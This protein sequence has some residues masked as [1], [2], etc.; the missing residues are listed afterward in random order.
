MRNIL[1]LLVLLSNFVFGDLS[2]YIKYDERFFADPIYKNY[3]EI[4][5]FQAQIKKW[6]I[7]K[8]KYGNDWNIKIDL[9]GG[10][11]GHIWGKGVPI[12]PGI[13]NNLE[14]Y[15]EINEEYLKKLCLNF[16]EEN[17]DIFLIDPNE[18]RF[19]GVYEE[20]DFWFVNMK[21]YFKGI[22]V[23]GS[24][25]FIK[26]SKGNIISFFSTK[27]GTI[28]INTNPNYTNI[29]ARESLFQYLGG[30]EENDKILEEKLLI[31]PIWKNGESETNYTGKVGE[32]YDH[33][34]VW[35]IRF[36]RKDEG[37]W[38]GIIDA[39]TNEVLSFN[40]NFVEGYYTGSITGSIYLHDKENGNIFKENVGMPYA[41]IDGYIDCYKTNDVSKCQNKDNLSFTRVYCTSGSG[42]FSYPDS[43]NGEFMTRLVS[44]YISVTSYL[45]IYRNY[46]CDCSTQRNPHGYTFMCVKMQNDPKCINLDGNETDN[47]CDYSGNPL[48]PDPYYNV[49]GNNNA[50][51]TAYYHGNYFKQ[52]WK[53]QHSRPFDWRT[54][55]TYCPQPEGSGLSQW[56]TSPTMIYVNLGVIPYYDDDDYVVL[57]TNLSYTNNNN[58]NVSLKNGGEYPS[59]LYHELGHGMDFHD[60]SCLASTEDPRSSTEGYADIVTAIM[61]RDSCLGRGMNEYGL[62]DEQWGGCVSNANHCKCIYCD[63]FREIDYTKRE[64]RIPPVE[65]WKDSAQCGNKFTPVGYINDICGQPDPQMG[66]CYHE[67]HCE[68]EIEGQAFWD[69][70]QNL[71]TINGYS[72]DKAWEV[73]KR[74]F[75]KAIFQIGPT[76]FQCTIDTNGIITGSNGCFSTSLFYGL[77][78]AD[79]GDGNANTKPAHYDAIYQAFSSHEIACENF[80]Q[81]SESCPQIEKPTFPQNAIQQANNTIYIKWNQVDGASSYDILRS[82]IGADRG[83]FAIARVYETSFVDMGLLNGIIYYYK[84]VPNSI[85]SSCIGEPSDFI[86]GIPQENVL[87]ILPE[88]IRPWL[89]DSFQKRQ[90]KAYGGSGNYT[91]S[92]SSGALPNGL[93]LNSSTG[94]IYGTPTNIGIYN[95]TIKAIDNE[96]NQIYGTRAYSLEIKSSFPGNLDFT[97]YYLPFAIRNNTYNVELVPSGG[98]GGYIFNI[99]EGELPPNFE[100]MHTTSPPIKWYINKNGQSQIGLYHFIISLTDSQNHYIEREFYLPVLNNEDDILLSPVE[101]TSAGGT[102]INLFFKSTVLP[103]NMDFY[104]DLKSND[105]LN[106][107]GTSLKA[108]SFNLIYAGSNNDKFIEIIS[109]KSLEGC[110]DIKLINKNTNLPFKTVTNG[111]K[112]K[113]FG[114]TSDQNNNS[115]SIIDTVE[116]KPFSYQNKIYGNQSSVPYGI[117]LSQDGRK[118]YSIDYSKGNLQIYDGSNFKYEGKIILQNPNLNYYGFGAIDLAIDSNNFGYIIHQTTGLEEYPEGANVWNPTFGGISVVDFKTN[119][120]IDID[121]NPQSTS[122]GAPDGYTRIDLNLYPYSISILKLQRNIEN[123]QVG[124]GFPGEYGFISGVGPQEP[125]VSI[126]RWKCYCIKSITPYEIC[127]FPCLQCIPPSKR[128]CFPIF[129]QPRPVRVAILDLNP[130]IVESINPDGTLNKAP[131]PNYWKILGG[132]DIGT[133]GQNLGISNQGISFSVSSDG[134]NATVYG[135]SPG[136]DK[137]YIFDFLEAVRNPFSFQYTTLSLNCTDNE[138]NYQNCYPT[139]IKVQKGCHLTDGTTKDLAFTTNSANDSISVINLNNTSNSYQDILEDLCVERDNWPISI[140]IRSDGKK[141]YVANYNSLKENNMST[142]SVLDLRNLQINAPMC[143]IEVGQGPIRVILQE[144]P[145]IND[146]YIGVKYEL[147]YAQDFDFTEPPKKDI[148]ISDWENIQKLQ[149]T[150]ANPQAVLSNIDNFQKNANKWIVNEN[151]KKDIE[152]KVGLYRASYIKNK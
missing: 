104:F 28:N 61:T 34:L 94:E 63:G 24:M 113:S 88:T 46:K 40:K 121:G 127:E 100:L 117:G 141:G 137:V 55:T 74:L 79:D 96:N 152:E 15:E 51:R 32:G 23:S 101:G 66:P 145:T 13:G 20:E 92:I 11:P 21:R 115:I 112:F 48:S 131:N 126:Q 124:D 19:S 16:I 41:D 29:Q 8:V 139:D 143:E 144:V 108:E 110:S 49:P 75:K 130:W 3:N 31:T 133:N 54:N 67:A 99:E 129:Y 59:V 119:E 72:E 4:S 76:F 2:N 83:Y 125:I 17:K 38:S 150:K 6:D 77:L 132:E 147:S 65:P 116:D 18:L 25:F 136:E 53:S 87:L 56:L 86:S 50:A 39:K 71:K 128:I 5:D 140:A 12:I 84:I 122:D 102:R 45:A 98:S 68:S 97:P 22:E 14:Y 135:V 27:Y 10:R 57:N 78:E 52:F 148:L 146:L 43:D 81:A 142:I 62:S 73:A 60:G 123:Y 107:I 42:Y 151:L 64:R 82:N 118:I 105:C 58:I 103:S 69:F 138:G 90:F 36:E 1:I 33:L 35:M 26:I 44:S 47:S 80:F 95:F 134:Q 109:P 9:R 85:N 89:K 114:F 30:M 111:Y 120:L 37:V 106:S 91:W 70:V 93:Y 149:E 7:F